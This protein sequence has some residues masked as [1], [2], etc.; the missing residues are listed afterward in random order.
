MPTIALQVARN[1]N[2]TSMGFSMS[3][4]ASEQQNHPTQAPQKTFSCVLCAQRKVKCDRRLAGCANCVKAHV[5]CIYRA[6]PRARRRKKGERDV[7]ATMRMRLYEDALRQLGVDPELVV[8]Q[9]ILNA[10][11]D[12]RST[13]TISVRG[14]NDFLTLSGP[15]KHEPDSSP[16]ETGIL[17]SE[18]GR[19]RY[20]ENGIWTSLQA[21][22]RDSREI[23][24]DS[25]DDG[26]SDMD[27][28]IAS[29]DNTPNRIDLLF[30]GQS[31]PVTLQSLHPNPVQ[32]F[33]LWQFYLDNINPIVKVFHAPTV[34]QLILDA[35]G[36][37]ADM[38]R[39]I[40]A[41]LF[42]IYCISAESMS[43]G[44]CITVLGQSKAPALRGFRRGAQC[45]LNNASVLKTSDLIVLQAFT[46][47][48]VGH[49]IATAT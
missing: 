32:I 41:L 42:A 5:P 4:E 14:I 11:T 23:L 28:I 21:E 38:P 24:D 9:R 33:K 39:N 17:V 40:E 48:I 8:K 3:E 10:S 46:L 34:Q 18:E 20:L 19:T 25:S 35:S 30:G 15:E 2:M 7:D 26:P 31:S 37:L 49:P 29:G 6:A 44:E 43:D 1:T 36:D 16:A 13:S 22:F 47:F 27:R 45:A 12:Q